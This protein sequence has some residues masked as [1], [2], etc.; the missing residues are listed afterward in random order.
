MD[1]R[2]ELRIWTTSRSNSDKAPFVPESRTFGE[3]LLSSDP[4]VPSR[5]SSVFE[6]PGGIWKRSRG[7]DVL[8]AL[9][10]AVWNGDD[11]VATPFQKG[12][13]AKVH[14]SSRIRR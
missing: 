14:P 4:A 9:A 6:H 13:S 12:G 2:S 1:D 8:I 5:V 11:D 7:G 10:K 3:I